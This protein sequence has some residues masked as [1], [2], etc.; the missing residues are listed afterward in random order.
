MKLNS[1]I[2]PNDTKDNMRNK[3]SETRLDQREDKPELGF[4]LC[5]NSANVIRSRGNPS[6]E[7]DKIYIDPNACTGDEKFLGGYHTHPKIDSD[8]SAND[9]VHCGR[10]KLAC[11]GGEL[12]NKI[13]C[14]IWKDMQ[15]SSEDMGKLADGYISGHRDPKYKKNFDC[16]DD[17]EPL[18]YEEEDL[19]DLNRGLKKLESDLH[20][21]ER[22]NIMISP[23]A[24]IQLS[25]VR[26]IRDRRVGTL[27]ASIKD[28]SKKYYNEVEI[29]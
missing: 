14:Y 24:R 21:L 5:A 29:K 2:L 10:S 3:L 26:T 7:S 6:G 1:Y 27:T 28:K 9:L 12:D 15:L 13:K 23:I 4:T 18:Y 11:I 8:A 19:K 22:D 25:M 16:I 20:D 17:F